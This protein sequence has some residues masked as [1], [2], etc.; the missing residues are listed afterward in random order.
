MV[1]PAPRKL[2]VKRLLDEAVVLKRLVVVA[3]LEVELPVILRLP[4]TVDEALP[5][6]RLDEVALMPS[7][8]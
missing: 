1:S 4:T 2:A 7:D 5:K 3:L 8:G 6:I